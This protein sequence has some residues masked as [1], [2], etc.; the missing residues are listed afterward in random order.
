ME[1]GVLS[2]LEGYNQLKG[3]YTI[4]MK[5]ENER[6]CRVG[7]LGSF[8]FGKGV[9]LYTGSARGKGSASIEGR[10][11]RHLGKR[12]RNFWHIDYLLSTG[13]WKI[14]AFIYSETAKDFECK[15]NKRIQESSHAAFP[16]KGFGSSD[17]S[18]LSH[19]VYL[20]QFGVDRAWAKAKNS[21][22]GL[23]LRPRLCRF[24]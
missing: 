13:S 10:K 6:R 19:L 24:N 16:V 23:R 22:V 14:Q 21:Y 1:Q 8:R 4:V 11:R 5:L 2:S 15:V 12:N 20:P 17:C 3:I 7:S 18:C 9:Y